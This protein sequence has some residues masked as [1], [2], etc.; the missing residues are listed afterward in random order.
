[1]NRTS[2]WNSPI[3]QKATQLAHARLRPTTLSRESAQ[4]LS[5]DILKSFIAESGCASILVDSDNASVELMQTLYGYAKGSLDLP[6]VSSIAA[7]AY[8]GMDLLLRYASQDQLRPLLSDIQNGEK[9]IAIAN[10]E[11]GA[12]TDIKEI[13]SLLECTH[14]NGLVLNK[15][16]STNASVAEVVITS[17]QCTENDAPP[18][19]KV[20]LF[21]PNSSERSDLRNQLAGFR[22]GYS[23]S[24]Q[25]KRENFTEYPKCQLGSNS[26][27]F[28]ILKRCFDTERLVLGVMAAGLLK[29]VEELFVERVKA[30]SKRLEKLL[31]HQYIQ[32]KLTDI[33]TTRIRLEALLSEVLTA[34]PQ[35][36]QS[37]GLLSVI[38]LTA[39]EE[40]FQAAISF[41]ESFGFE[42][43]MEENFA[44]KLVRDILSYRYF[45]GTKELHKRTIFNV[46]SST[47]FPKPKKVS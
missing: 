31:K 40:G 27:G 34:D 25:T 43:M 47:Y 21:E 42:A 9:I 13:G 17:L 19:V 8:V 38:K 11:L 24:I 18:T 36:E 10:A 16:C 4:T 5:P 12:G 45:G 37:E 23:G 22:S 28:N 46:L 2:I 30:S 41:F 3:V 15:S 26:D 35:L 1:M 39:L 7:H 44:H 33:Y 29:G 14:V 20:I 32:E 6:F